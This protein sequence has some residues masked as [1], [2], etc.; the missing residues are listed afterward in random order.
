[1]SPGEVSATS[2]QP[3]SDDDESNQQL[4]CDGGPDEDGEGDKIG[5]SC[6]NN[7]MLQDGVVV[8]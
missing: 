7:V 3:I 2:S 5:G 1:M 6:D 4:M 8:G